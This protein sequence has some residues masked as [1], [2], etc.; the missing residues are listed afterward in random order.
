MHSDRLC[1]E[2]GKEGRGRG[3]EGEGHRI[4]RQADKG[5]QQ[6]AHKTFVTQNISGR[7]L[8]HVLLVVTMKVLIV[9]DMSL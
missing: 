2:E 1:S 8:C 9:D 4:E 6:P 7:F 5:N 3:G